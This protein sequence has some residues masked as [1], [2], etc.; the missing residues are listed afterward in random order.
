M[1]GTC[2]RFLLARAARRWPADLRA[3]MLTEWQAELHAMPGGWRRLRYAASLATSEPHRRPGIVLSPARRSVSAVMSFLLVAVLPVAYLPVMIGWHSYYTLD[4]ITWQVWVA[5]AGV[6]GAVLLGIICARVTTGVTQL[7]NP[8]LVPLW[9]VAPAYLALLA[10]PVW[11]GR[12]PDR[13]MVIDLSC[14]ALSAVVLG[15]VAARIA[16]AGRPWLSRGSV[17]LAVAVAFWFSHMH[18]TLSHFESSMTY[19]FGGRFLPAFAFEV[20]ANG[21]LHITIFLLV[22]AHHL[23]RRHRPGE[24]VLIERPVAV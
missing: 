16:L 19:F 21:Y 9:A 18:N 7:I 20:A 5:G 2:C 23:V 1:I 10:L 14:W 17:V 4:T 13:A 24:P 11:E 3:E 15:T 22:Y 8:L 12:L 6:V